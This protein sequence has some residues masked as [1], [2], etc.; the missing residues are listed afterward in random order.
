MIRVLVYEDNKARQEALEM[1][2]DHTADMAFAGVRPDCSQVIQDIIETRPDVV[3]MDI[4]MPKVNGVEGL[5]VIK[6]HFPH[7]PVIMQTIFETEEKIF[8][9]IRSGAQGYILKKTTGQKLIEGIREVLD[10]GAPMTPSVARKVLEMYH[11]Q[12]H[13]GRNNSFSLSD[14][15]LEILGY[16][17]KGFSYKMIAD[18]ADITWHTVN[19][20][21]KK[22]YEKLQVHSATEAISKAIEQK[23]V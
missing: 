2:L 8:D 12:T 16:L 1:L 22:I 7:L 6:M 9:A 17:V 13:P 10:G 23:I 14:R 21:I 20:H 18:A 19:G 3:L 5:K 4:D 11:R 15:E